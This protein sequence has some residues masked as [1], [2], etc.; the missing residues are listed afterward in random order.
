MV[1]MKILTKELVSKETYRFVLFCV[2]AVFWLL[3]LLVLLKTDV[4][5]LP[6]LACI[7]SLQFLV[8]TLYT[9]CR[10]A[11]VKKEMLKEQG[12]LKFALK[13]QDLKVQHL[14]QQHQQQH[15]KQ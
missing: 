11:F 13:V 14:L 2:L 1:N 3:E 6:Y 8:T 10:V 5:Y 7:L 12:N 4:P 9:E 15:S